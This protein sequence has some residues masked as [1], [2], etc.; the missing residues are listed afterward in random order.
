MKKKTILF[1]TTFL[2]IVLVLIFSSVFYINT[3][4]PEKIRFV[5]NLLP[6]NLK[7]L[8]KE[9]VCQYQYF[10]PEYSNERMFPKT[11]FLKLNYNEIEIKGLESQERYSEEILRYGQKVVPFYIETFDERN[12]L[13]AMNGTT[14]SYDTTSF[15][16]NNLPKNYEI[17]NNLPQDITVDGT[18]VYEN[19]IFVSFRNKN[20]S[21]DN[22]EVYMADVNFDVLNFKE[23]YSH[24]SALKCKTPYAVWGG[25][26]TT[27]KD[28]DKAS[29]ILST[30]YPNNEN[31]ALLKNY[32]KKRET[33]MMLIDLNTKKS[34]PFTAG[35][36][37]PQGIFVNKKNIIISTE[38]GPRGG[39]EINKII[40]GNNYGWP[41]RSYGEGGENSAPNHSQYGFVEPI[42]AF[43]PSIA[44]SQIIEAPKEFSPK[45]QNSYLITTLKGLSIYRVIFDE[46]YSRV[47]TTEKIRIGKRIRDITYNKKYN[48]FILALENEN[49]SIGQISLDKF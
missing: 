24:G 34:R 47:I 27:Y 32:N 4:G 9:Q 38:H 8:I 49:G 12:I 3:Q 36:R 35:H 7:F 19:Q 13:I 42:F 18:M 15:V 25:Q 28:N 33:I 21:C 11:Q 14:L 46:D 45:W 31:H 6:N 2:I 22:R 1:L 26:I 40:E 16:K 29:I 48:S 23:F 43:T 37:N 20:K 39:D 30:S 41:S 10:V 44:I 17:K 5:K